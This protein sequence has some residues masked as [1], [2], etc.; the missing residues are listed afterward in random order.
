MELKKTL[1]SVALAGMTFAAGFG[2]YHATHSKPEKRYTSSEKAKTYERTTAVHYQKTTYDSYEVRAGVLMPLPGETTTEYEA[3]R[4]R[5]E[6]Q[7]NQLRLRMMRHYQERLATL[8]S[9]K[10]NPR[11]I[12]AVEDRLEE[13]QKTVSYLSYNTPEGQK[14]LKVFNENQ[15]QIKGKQLRQGDVYDF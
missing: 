6:K 10:A 7:E 11:I 5:L 15:R 1:K 3:R 13:L 8:R 2:A 9:Q 14:K 4:V 12:D